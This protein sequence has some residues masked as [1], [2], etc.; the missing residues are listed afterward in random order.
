[1]NEEARREF[2][3]KTFGEMVD[4]ILL[5]RKQKE[6]ITNENARFRLYFEHICESI[7]E[8]SE[9][10][11]VIPKITPEREAD[12]RRDEE[13]REREAAEESVEPNKETY[14]S[15]EEVRRVAVEILKETN[16]EVSTTELSKKVREKISLNPRKSVGEYLPELIKAGTILK[17]GIYSGTF[18]W[19]NKGEIPPETPEPVKE[20][21]ATEG[22]VL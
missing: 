3:G 4:E 9:G 19:I 20:S 14:A 5:L 22:A 7:A 1:M 21:E 8:C 12:L 2:D 17:R 15:G 18:Y 11:A 16:G 6:Q 10:V 13:E